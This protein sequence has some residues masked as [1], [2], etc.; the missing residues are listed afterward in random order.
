MNLLNAIE[1]LKNEI[2]GK[3]SLAET[4]I[5]NTNTL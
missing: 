3:E 4:E 1:L 5:K 2:Q